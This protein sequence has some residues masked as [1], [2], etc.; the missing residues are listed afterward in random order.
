MDTD[1][2]PADGLRRIALSPLEKHADP[3]GIRR[4]IVAGIAIAVH[5]G[6][7]GGVRDVRPVT[8]IFSLKLFE[9]LI[10]GFSPTFQE[11]DFSVDGIY[12]P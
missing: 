9:S 8:N 7:V 10:V 4:A 5:I 2:F 6:E 3:A 1:P 11:G 12:R